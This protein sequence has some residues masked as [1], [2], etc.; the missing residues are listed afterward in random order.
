M[1]R[2]RWPEALW[3]RSTGQVMGDDPKGMEQLLGI[4]S[5]TVDYDEDAATPTPAGREWGIDRRLRGDY[6]ISPQAVTQALAV[7]PRGQATAWIR[8]YRPDRPW[9]GYVQL[10]GFGATLDRLPRFARRRNMGCSERRLT[11]KIGTTPRQ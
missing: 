3:S 8:V 6:P 1:L 10:W 9:A 5:T 4:S 7:N 2:R 11:I